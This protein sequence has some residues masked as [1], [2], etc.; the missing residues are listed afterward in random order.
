MSTNLVSSIAAAT[1][2]R[3]VTIRSNA[4]L[5]EAA[6]L[7]SSTNISLLVVCD[8]EGTMIGVITK[9]D[10]VMQIG[11][12][13]GVT[14]TNTVDRVMRRDVIACYP[15]DGLSDVLSM[16]QARGLVHVPVIDAEGKPSGV[17]NARDAL[18]ELMLEG[19]YE[20]AL[21]RDYVMGVGYR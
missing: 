21:L 13:T 17:V 19:Q 20:E 2:S 15:A 18:R 14:C 8:P 1:R 10:I 3:L 16:M 7:L 12:C 5:R 6:Q 9:S 4:P 11:H